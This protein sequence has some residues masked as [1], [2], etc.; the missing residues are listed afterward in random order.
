MP[1][2]LAIAVTRVGDVDQAAD[3]LS[4]HFAVTPQP[5][6]RA[7]PRVSLKGLCNAW[8][9]PLCPSLF[10]LHSQPLVVPSLS[11]KKNKTK[12]KNCL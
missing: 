9:R 4:C 10:S 1:T 6:V 3:L 7:L 8:L 5:A 12:Q 2:G 11:W